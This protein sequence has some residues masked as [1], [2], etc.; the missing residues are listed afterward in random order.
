MK[1]LLSCFNG[2]CPD[3]QSCCAS[4]SPEYFGIAHV[5][6]CTDGAGVDEVEAVPTVDV[7][8]LAE[9]QLRLELKLVCLL[10]TTPF[11]C[12]VT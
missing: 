2:A 8:S 10:S 4:L 11:L 7:D 9:D 12:P 1:I 6:C 3:L 5:S